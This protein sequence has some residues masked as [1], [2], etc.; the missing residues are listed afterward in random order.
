[1]FVSLEEKVSSALVCPWLPGSRSQSGIGVPGP[2]ATLRRIS[3]PQP[4]TVMGDAGYG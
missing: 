2:Q 1:M 3:E 4:L